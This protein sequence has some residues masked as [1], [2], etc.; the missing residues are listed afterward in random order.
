MFLT[1]K[2]DVR[3]PL[4][5]IVFWARNEMTYLSYFPPI[6]SDF[7]KKIKQQG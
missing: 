3:E 1:V 7:K 6:W 2:F 4:L 5:V